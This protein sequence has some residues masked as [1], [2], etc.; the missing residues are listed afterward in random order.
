MCA[1]RNYIIVLAVFT[2]ITTVSAV[3]RDP[4]PY[5]AR[6]LSVLSAIQSAELELARELAL[7]LVADYP[8]SRIGAALLGDIYSGF[9]S[10]LSDFGLQLKI[11]DPEQAQGLHHELLARKGLTDFYPDEGLVPAALLDIGNAPYVILGDMEHSRLYVYR[12][13]DGYPKLVADYYMTIGLKGIGKQVE[14]DQRTPVGVYQITHFIPDNEL[15]DLY[16]AGAYPVDYP[17]VLDKGLKRTGYGIWLHGTPSDQYSR[18][19]YASDG[20]FVVSNRDFEDLAKYID[21]DVG[22]PVLLSAN[23]EWVANESVETLKTHFMDS[24]REWEEA[25]ESLDVERYQQLYN[26]RKFGFSSIAFEKWLT[27]KKRVIQTAKYIRV[28]TAISG[29]FVYP[30]EQ[31]T[32]LVKYA[33][34]FES[35]TF[36]DN[37]QKQMY[38]QR[39]DVGEWRII[40]EGDA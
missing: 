36:K 7:T 17:N 16:G 21:G 4:D 20:C 11:N 26:S 9:N 31:D 19:P 3:D 27:G 2:F 40:Y 35:D 14:G 37:S 22:T 24:F 29:L 28:D 13:E 18:V 8:T 33:Q 12:N 15:P 6:L 10:P 1:S 5:E 39:N 30:G 23:V 34:K 38:W 25:W 32:I